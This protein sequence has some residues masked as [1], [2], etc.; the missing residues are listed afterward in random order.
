MIGLYDVAP[1]AMPKAI[2]GSTTRKFFM[3]AEQVEWDYAP[4]GYKQCTNEDVSASAQPL[5]TASP[6][7]AGSKRAKALFVQYTDASMTSKADRPAHFGLMGPVLGV[8]VGNV[9]EVTLKNN[10]PFPIS[11][12]PDG[13]LVSMH[14]AAL[15][16]EIAPGASFTYRYMVPAQAGPLPGDLSTVAFHYASDVDL[17]AHT[18]AGLF[19]LL[20]ISAPGMLKADGITPK[21]ADVLL[22]LHFQVWQCSRGRMFFRLCTFLCTCQS[23]PI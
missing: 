2:T 19:G 14:D 5:L 6:T 15:G 22:P 17:P 7:T 20:L 10:L 3:A 12:A 13:G 9:L 16:K 18:T 11:F 1:A 21:D 23:P 8:E 4:Q